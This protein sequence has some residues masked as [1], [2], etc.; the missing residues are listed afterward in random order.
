MVRA[1]VEDVADEAPVEEAEEVI[2]AAVEEAPAPGFEGLRKSSNAWWCPTCDR[3][4]PFDETVCDNC[5]YAR[6]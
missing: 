2:E 6:S 3:A 1:K 4:H 5:G